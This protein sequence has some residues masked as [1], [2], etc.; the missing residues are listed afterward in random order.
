MSVSSA[1]LLSISRAVS[2]EFA[3]R[4]SNGA[5]LAHGMA[6]F[7]MQ[8]LTEIAVS[9]RHAY[10][11]GRTPDAQ[12]LLLNRKPGSWLLYWQ[13]PGAGGGDMAWRIRISP[14]C[15]PGAAIAQC[16][17][18]PDIEV[19]QAQGISL[20]ELPVGEQAWRYQAVLGHCDA[21]QHFTP[22]L[23]ADAESAPQHPQPLYMQPLQQWLSHQPAWA[24]SSF[25]HSPSFS[26]QGK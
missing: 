9:I 6:A 22:L 3:P 2:R 8:E 5:A 10:R 26:E 1:E 4:Y 13:M 11:W 21:Q 17:S 18:L 24:A 25:V 19:S 16:A 7:S 12:L 20:L 15:L 14:R 23:Y